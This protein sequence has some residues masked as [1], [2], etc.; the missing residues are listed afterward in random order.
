MAYHAAAATTPAAATTTPVSLCVGVVPLALSSDRG[1]AAQWEVGAWAEGGN[2]PDAK[3]SL[4]S[5]AGAGAPIFTFG[6][7]AGNGTSACDLG[8]VD[9]SSAQRLFQA[10]VNVPITAT[11]LNAVSLT[12]TGTAVNLS[13]NPA[14][15]ASVTLL[16]AGTPSPAGSSASVASSG[17]T[18][19]SPSMSP[20]GNAADLFPTVAPG[21]ST[22]KE[23]PVANVSALHTGGT[24]VGPEIAEVTGLGALA[25]AMFL[26]L[27][28]LSFRRPAPRHAAGSPAAAVPPP[29]PPAPPAPP[30]E[31]KE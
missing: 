21:S 26:A 25:V 12:V 18:F 20:G 30:A 8:A 14:A 23:S 17:F 15:A 9:A 22:G 31:P 3:L 5:T 16:A 2:L 19:P 4:T 28:R 10:E 6:C 13:A 24:A 7:A 29:M 11:A 1:A 27:T